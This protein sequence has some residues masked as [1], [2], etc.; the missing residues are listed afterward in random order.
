MD[1]W[2]R[3][4]NMSKR[5]LGIPTI[6]YSGTTP[7]GFIDPRTGL[8][9]APGAAK[10]IMWLGDSKEDQSVP[11][12]TPLVTDKSLPLFKPNAS[13]FFPN[14]NTAGTFIANISIDYGAGAGTGVLAFTKSTNSLQWTAPGDSAGSAVDVSLGGWFRLESA[15]AGKGC[16][17]S[18]LVRNAP[19]SDKSDNLNYS[20]YQPS[21]YYCRTESVPA[22]WSLLNGNPF[23]ENQWFYAIGGATSSD[24]ITAG[25]WSNV[26]T[27]ITHI[28]LT[29][30]G[31]STLADVTT[32][33]NNIVSIIT[34]RLNIGSRVILALPNLDNLDYTVNV[35]IPKWKSYLAEKLR[36]Y[37]RA[38]NIEYYSPAEFLNTGNSLSA[39][40]VADNFNLD[41]VHYSQRGSY[42]MAKYLLDPILSKYAPKYIGLPNP[43]VSYD[44]TNAPNGNL[45]VNGT[46]VGTAGTANAGTSGGVPTSWT[47]SRGSGSV[48]LPYFL[49]SQGQIKNTGIW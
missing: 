28:D 5:S 21:V 4:F 46:L 1:W 43:L 17:V 32:T 39:P 44:A 33:Y 10:S 15:T 16:Y 9:I 3:M 35:N 38:N 27:D 2:R 31:F 47:A 6:A 12:S 40:N 45:I 23:G 48:L 24:I 25:G 41:T 30:N 49:L 13:G 42:L 7:V 14:L 18:V 19:A 20:T 34:S 36:V 8:P 29:T 11:Y 37:C 26:Y 22:M